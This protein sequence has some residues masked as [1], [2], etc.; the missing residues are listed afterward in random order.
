M[1]RCAVELIRGERNSLWQW[2]QFP[3]RA[4][5]VRVPLSAFQGVDLTEI[6]SLDFIFDQTA[7]GSLLLSM[8][9]FV[10]GSG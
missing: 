3:L 2:S 4:R 10:A 6:R 1:A 8:V 7:Q 9:E 5:S